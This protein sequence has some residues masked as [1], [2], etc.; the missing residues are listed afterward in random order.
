MYSHCAVFWGVRPHTPFFPKMLHSWSKLSSASWSMA[1][2]EET[3][4][5]TRHELSSLTLNFQQF[6]P[7]TL[8]HHYLMLNTTCRGFKRWG[9][10]GHRRYFRSSGHC[11]IICRQ[12]LV[13]WGVVRQVSQNQS[14]RSILQGLG[15]KPPP[16]QSLRQSFPGEW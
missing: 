16:L 10:S 15:Q 2:A 7:G 12:R 11:S 3:R 4:L 5:R 9:L 6:N 14:I 1:R 8:K 13:Y